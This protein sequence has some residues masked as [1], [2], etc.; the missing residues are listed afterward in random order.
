MA[1]K[2]Y[3]E[4]QSVDRIGRGIIISFSDGRT[5][6]FSSELLCSLRHHAEEILDDPD[7]D[8]HDT[9]LDAE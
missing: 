6:L 3:S 4:V 2:E 8:H 7:D 5:V 9:T 1:Q